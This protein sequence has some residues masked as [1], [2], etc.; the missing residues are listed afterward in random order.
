MN[1][2]NWLKGFAFLFLLLV[3]SWVFI[4]LITDRLLWQSHK[5]FETLYS[6]IDFILEPSTKITFISEVVAFASAVIALAIPL[7]HDIISRISEKYH[8]DYIIE[9]FEQ[10]RSV[11]SLTPTLLITILLAVL[12]LFLENYD[13]A[14]VAASLLNKLIFVL[15]LIELSVFYFFLGTVKKYSRNVDNI[16]NK[17]FSNAGTFIR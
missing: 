3:W 5:P 4:L 13:G 14:K 7:S 1:K 17:L 8:S 15:F 2:L 9:L 12:S 11:K 16:L 6:V 10:E